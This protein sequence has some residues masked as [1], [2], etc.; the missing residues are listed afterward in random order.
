MV[1]F[2]LEH[3]S[4]EIGTSYHERH[5]VVLAAIKA[6]SDLDTVIHQ[7]CSAD[8][9]DLVVN[10]GE[11]AAAA[12]VQIV[13]TT[14]EAESRGVIADSPSATTTTWLVTQSPDVRESAPTV[15]KTARAIRR[16]ELRVVRAAL[17]NLDITPAVAATIAAEYD[18]LAPALSVD[19]KPVVL[20]QFLSVGGAHGA[21]AVRQLHDEIIATFGPIGA[22]DDLHESRQHRIELTSGRECSGMWHYQLTT[23]TEGRAALESAIGPLSKPERALDG[24]P[25]PRPAGRR[26]GQAL[27]EALRRA[28][29]AAQGVPIQPKATLHIAMNLDDLR[30]HTGAGTVLGRAA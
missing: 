18:K 21:R 19:A 2:T 26:R 9:A 11:L 28:T 3:M 22:Y 8:L 23:D 25:D 7:A 29:A 27:I 30:E 13:A 6:V 14:A 16:P 12:T 15:S 20:K 4:G 5:E 1:V 10:L 17:V 24:T